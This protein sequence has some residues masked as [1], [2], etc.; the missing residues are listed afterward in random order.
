MTRDRD[1]RHAEC[2]VVA[3]DIVGEMCLGLCHVG[4]LTSFDRYSGAALYDD[5][6]VS[7]S[8]SET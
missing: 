2:P 1:G 8:K 3:E 4:W 5:S 7:L 6:K